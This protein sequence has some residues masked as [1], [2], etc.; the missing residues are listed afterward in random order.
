MDTWLIVLMN[1]GYEWTAL[2]TAIV[3]ENE[4]GKI[5][6]ARNLDFYQISKFDGLFYRADVY[7]G[8]TF[9]YSSEMVIGGAGALTGTS[10]EIGINVNTRY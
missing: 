1:Y 4:D 8:D 9:I 2:C 7:R 5:I 3:A 10:T 6:H